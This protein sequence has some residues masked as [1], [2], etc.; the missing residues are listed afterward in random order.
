M[1]RVV[2]LLAL[3]VVV[4]SLASAAQ[5]GILPDVH[6]YQTGKFV[7]VPFRGLA[8]WLGASVQYKKH[9]ITMEYAGK[10]VKLTMGSKIAQVNGKPVTMQMAPAV[11][12]GVACVPLRFVSEAFGVTTT[13]H[14]SAGKGKTPG[15]ELAK[16]G[17]LPFVDLQAPGKLGRI[18]VHREPPHLVSV[19]IKDLQPATDGPYGER[20]II[21]IQQ[22][23]A[24]K[25]KVKG[26][27]WH[28]PASAGFSPTEMS[29][30]DL[31]RVHGHWALP[32][33]TR[34]R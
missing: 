3:L 2:S 15:A 22:V 32:P 31:I 19:I 17:N 21:S 12:D 26:P 24:R 5:L 20:W 9:V 33:E 8:E 11:Y 25:V 7:V 13:F 1:R 34:D 23:L 28:A 29:G 14:E 27:V 18:V 16:M 4:A 10:S 30:A 6:G